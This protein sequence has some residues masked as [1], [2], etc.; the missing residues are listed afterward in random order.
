MV[1]SE[2]EGLEPKDRSP[3]VRRKARDSP[4]I[5]GSVT[6]HCA[7]AT[8]ETAP[9]DDPMSNHASRGLTDRGPHT[10]LM[11]AITKH[12]WRAGI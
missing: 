8:E 4:D 3:A 9:L 7:R 5:E 1:R 12:E 11:T 2:V 6:P 10:R